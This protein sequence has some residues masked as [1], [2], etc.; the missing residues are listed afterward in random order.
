[1]NAL[2]RAGLAW[3][4]GEEVDQFEAGLAV[5][6]LVS[7][8]LVL[9]SGGAS[10]TVEVGVTGLR[11]ARARPRQ[12]SGDGRAGDGGAGDGGAGAGANR[13][14]A[15]GGRQTGAAPRARPAKGGCQAP[16]FRAMIAPS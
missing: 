7:T 15:G 11:L 9:S 13:R 16:R 3:S 5:A 1:M 10:A 4:L 2:R 6:G 8:G 14:G 12:R